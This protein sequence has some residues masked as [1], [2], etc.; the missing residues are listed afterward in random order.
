MA[1]VERL[2]TSVELV[3]DAPRRYSMS[4]RHE[5][6]LT[7][8]SRVLL[9]DDRGWTSG[10]HSYG[11]GDGE[12]PD[13]WSLQS[14][15]GIEQDARHVVGPDESVDEHWVYLAGILERQGVGADPGELS[16][17]PHDVVLGERVLGRLGR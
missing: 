5:A 8:G 4:A 7:D 11:D 13:M 15:E 2:V 10:L 3:D 16:R 17:L 12:L 1:A 9:L 6:V 14:A